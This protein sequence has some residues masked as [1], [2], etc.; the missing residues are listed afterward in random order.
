M[1]M[2]FYG[3]RVLYI[4]LISFFYTS[5]DDNIYHFNEV[6]YILYIFL[7][8]HISYVLQKKMSVVQ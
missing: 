5:C 6:R 3:V 8:I 4:A 7:V 2:K 1:C